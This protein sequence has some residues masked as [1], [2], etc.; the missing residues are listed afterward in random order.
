M[1]AERREGR[2]GGRGG[3]LRKAVCDW[4]RKV[5]KSQVEDEWSAVAPLFLV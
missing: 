4:L 1:R 5:I 3:E 2:E